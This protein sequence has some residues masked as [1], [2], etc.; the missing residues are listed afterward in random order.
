MCGCRVGYIVG[1]SKVI[2]M[3]GRLKSNFDYGI[4]L[5]LQAAGIAALTG[6]QKCVYEAVNIYQ[7]RRDI[8]IVGLNSGGWPIE[9]PKASL[10]IWA[11]IPIKQKSLDFAI[12]M[13]NNTRVIATPGNAFGE[14]GEGFI[15]MAL[16][17]SEERLAE[18]VNRINKW[19]KTK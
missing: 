3:I 9:R 13:F 12:D 11:K 6:P 15:R 1:N 2:S 7:R 17:E 5:P 8:I 14:Y 19:L 18:A 16:V 10:Y 4:F